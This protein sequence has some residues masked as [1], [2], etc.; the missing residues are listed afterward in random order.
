V[1][2]LIYYPFL[3]PPD[4]EWLKFALL[5]FDQFEP[6]IPYNR[7]GEISDVFKRLLDET[8]LIHPFSPDY[9]Q[10]QRAS[11]RTVEEAEK[12]FRQ[13]ERAFPFRKTNLLKTWTEPSAWDSQLYEEKFSYDFLAFCKEN[14]IG[15]KTTDGLLLPEELTF[16]FMT[17]LAK[18]ISYDREASIIT[19]SIRYDDYTNFSHTLAKKPQRI[20]TFAKGIIN[21]LVPG[22]LGEISYANLI[23][24]RKNHR[25]GIR[26]FNVELDNVETS[27]GQ[28]ITKRDFI[29]SFNSIYSDFSKEVIIQ[30]IGV[31]AIPFAAYILINNPQALAAEYVKETLGGLGFVLG[32][33]YSLG[34]LWIDKKNKRYCKKYLTNLE[35]LK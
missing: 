16:M 22:N 18:E 12:M 32:G 34:K 15:E 10:G 5:Y 25:E 14:K 26:S 29:E 20:G 3:E 21:L 23:K 35:R 17:N 1:K 33:T 11:V 19:D 9:S 28:G 4:Q 27:I 13:P 7:R 31:A 30:G 6:I 24:F 2:N 8:D